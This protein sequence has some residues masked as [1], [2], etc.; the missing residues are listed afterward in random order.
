MTRKMSTVRFGRCGVEVSR[1]ALGTWSYGGARSV[2][3]RPVG[4]GGHDDDTALAAARRSWELGITHW[5]TADAYGD[6]HAERLLG[7]CW[8]NVPR[9]EIFLATKVG[10]VK[11]PHPHYYHPEQ[12]RRQL[13]GS[14][15]RLATERIDLYYF[16][17]CDFGPDDVYLD[18]ALE[19]VERARESGKIRFVGL[20]DW[21]A[22]KIV[23]LLDRI[24]PDV[25]QP[26]RNVVDDTYRSSGLAARVEADD[27][28]VAFFSP[29]KH[30]LLTGKYEG[31]P[32]FEPGDMRRN[33]RGFRDPGLLERLRQVRRRIEARLEHPHPVLQALVGTLLADSPTASVLVGQRN[34][35]QVE[36]AATLGSPLDP[37]TAAWVHSLYARAEDGTL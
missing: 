1:V 13:D 23:R 20:S 31:P 6:G 11:G 25:V 15:E 4:W 8:T 2:G 19:V 3:A 32:E 14:L 29:L 37:E 7:R 30:G 35:E 33:V 5:D 22:A 27:L 12:V 26:Y 36:A 9:D 21:S 24:D 18:G 34:P 17:H 10:W 16:H 28:G